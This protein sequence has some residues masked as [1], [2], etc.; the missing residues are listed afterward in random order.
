MAGVTRMSS[1]VPSWTI[2][3]SRITAMR[4]PRRMASLR[5]WVMKTM[6]FFSRFC[7]SS[8]W[9]CMSR[10]ISGSS[11]LKDSSISSRSASVARARARPTRCCM[12][13]DSS[14]GQDF[15]Q[16]YQAGQLQ[17][18]GGALL[19]LGTRYALHFQAVPGV[20]Q[21]AAVGEQRE[22]LEHHADLGGP[23]VSQLGGAQGGQVLA[24]EE[25]A[26]GRGLQKSVEHAQQRG[27]SGPG[28]THHDEDLSRFDG[29]RG[30]DHRCGRSVGAQLVAVGAAF[31]LLHGLIG[32]SAEHFVQ[33]FSLQP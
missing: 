14:S 20:L 28:Q 13:P 5:S 31:E 2:F 16:L 32:S 29:E 6:V 8:S 11:A 24:V 21:H 12:P 25:H 4:S 18:L 7:S 3:P 10:R 33:A 27:L 1:A 22:V 17:R 19:A 26:S 15:S 30:V 9:S 23:D